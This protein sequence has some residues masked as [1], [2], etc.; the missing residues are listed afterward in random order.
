MRARLALEAGG[1]EVEL[2]EIFFRDKAPELLATSPK[3]T[4]P[5]LTDDNGLLLEESLDIIRWA[6]EISDAGSILEPDAGSTAK[7]LAL[8]ERMDADFKPHLDHY[9]YASRYEDI[10]G[11]AARSTASGFLNELDDML[12]GQPFLYGHKRS[13]GDIGVAPFVRQFAHVDQ[14]WFYAQDWKNLI[15]WLDA[16]KASPEFLRIMHKYPKWVAGDDVTLFPP[17]VL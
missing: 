6:M 1:I 12:A 2:R 14:D 15:D 16:F 13:V 10:D 5:V 9:K 7:A 3:G 17:M 4:V 11:N 8:I